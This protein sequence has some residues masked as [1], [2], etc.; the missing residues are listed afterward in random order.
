MQSGVYQPIICP[1]CRL[2]TAPHVEDEEGLIVVHCGICGTTFGFDLSQ[3][4]PL[5]GRG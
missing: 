5:T 1:Q 2:D 3:S 4:A